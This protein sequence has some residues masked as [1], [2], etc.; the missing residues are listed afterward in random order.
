MERARQDYI[1]RITSDWQR[2]GAW[3]GPSEPD[4]YANAR[5]PAQAAN[6]VEA[7]RRRWTRESPTDAALSDRDAAYGEYVERISNAWRR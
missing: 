2:R 5:D 7:Q 6:A 3:A 4:A 1:E